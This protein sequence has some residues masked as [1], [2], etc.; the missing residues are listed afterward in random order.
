MSNRFNSI[1]RNIYVTGFM[2][3]GKSTL[4]R[5]LANELDLPYKDLDKE[6]EMRERQTIQKIFDHKGEAY[7]RNKEHSTLIDLTET[8]KGIVSLGGG[9]LQDQH[10]V[11]LLKTKGILISVQ[12]PF[13]KI[14]KRVQS[15][16]ERPILYD[17]EGKIKSEAT[18]KTELKTLY[19][20]RLRFY[21]QAQ[22]TLDTSEFESQQDLIKAAID[23]IKRHV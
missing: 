12:A 23:K 4:A 5:S 1:E 13:E 7:F 2:A 22:I 3:S 11:D 15:S 17:K 14:V 8:F 10:L 16:T 19:S 20:N 6:I 21:E 18:L 9:A